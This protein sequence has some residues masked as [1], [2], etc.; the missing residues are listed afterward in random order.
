MRVFLEECRFPPGGHVMDQ[1]AQPLE[2]RTL[3]TKNR[4]FRAGYSPV[5]D[6]LPERALLAAF[7]W[8]L[9]FAEAGV[10][11]IISPR[12][13]VRPAGLPSELPAIHPCW[14]EHVGQVHA[15]GC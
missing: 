4:I 14:Q 13:V 5:G 11:A 2:F 15:L 10:G 12:T 8:E 1:F 3:K 9:R 6:D 7:D